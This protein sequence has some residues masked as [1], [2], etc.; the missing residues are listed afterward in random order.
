MGYLAKFYRT[1][2]SFGF[3][4]GSAA[5]AAQAVSKA[6]PLSRRRTK[7]LRLKGIAHPIV[8]RLGTSDWSVLD[9]VFMSREYD[10]RSDEHER[11]VSEF[12]HG[13]ISRS[14][15]PLI[16]DCGANIGLAS[17]WYAQKFPRAK[18]IAI[19]PEPENFRILT[20]N[21][22]SYPNIE[23]V[24]AGISDHETRISLSNAGDAPWAWETTETALGEVLTCTIPTLL[25][26]VPNAKLM[27]VKID[28]EGSEVTLFRSNVDWVT[29]TPVIVFEDHDW[30]FSWRGTFHAVASVLVKERRDYLHN[31]ENT[32]SFSHSLL[33][34]QGHRA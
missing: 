17:I 28:V 13:L 27:I 5:F 7:K 6:G 10:C 31:G 15:V 22:A 16:I 33:S 14:E 12:Y 2:E 34:P 29:Q 19:E 26:N 23:A 21:T 25:A 18:I 9:Q 30:L 1:V 20:I 11:S 3:W 8:L 24:H 4:Q 32:F